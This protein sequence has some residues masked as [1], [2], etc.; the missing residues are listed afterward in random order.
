MAKDSFFNDISLWAREANE[1]V[2]IE[3]A[4]VARTIFTMIAQRS[5][6]ASGRFMA[7]WLIGPT[8]MNYSTMSVMERPAKIA[9]INATITADYFTKHDQVWMV[10]NVT[11][12]QNVEYTG[13]AKTSKYAPVANTLAE[14][15]NGFAPVGQTIGA[16]MGGV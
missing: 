1:E 4:R 16:I 2:A 11:Y 5:P 10:N 9:E 12:A 7:N 13:W 14:V 8:D 6:V 15:G 3:T